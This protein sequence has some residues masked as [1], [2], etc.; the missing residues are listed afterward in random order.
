MVTI[1]EGGARAD[2]LQII[3]SA[4]L[5]APLVE[6]AW[7]DDESPRRAIAAS[8]WRIVADDVPHLIYSVSGTAGGRRSRLHLVGPRTVF[9]D[10]NVTRRVFTV[11]LR[12][13]PGVATSLFGLPT[14]Q[15]TNQSFPVND[16]VPRALRPMVARIEDDGPGHVVHNLTTLVRSLALVAPALDPRAALFSG[17]AHGDID[18]IARVFGISHRGVRSWSHRVLGMGLKRFLRIQRLHRAVQL[19]RKY[20]TTTWSTLAAHSGYADQSHCIRDFRELLGETPAAFLAR[21]RAK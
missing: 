15:T 11:G 16:L 17:V 18:R 10:I 12:L 7:I 20:P 13:R 19:G 5:L 14:S 4:G 1:D 6:L 21:G 3:P 9:A 8:G 2:T